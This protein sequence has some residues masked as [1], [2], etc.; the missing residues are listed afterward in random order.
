MTI[1]SQ[2]ASW[3]WLLL[4]LLAL[5][6]LGWGQA[7]P[8]AAPLDGIWKGS[9]PVPGGQL[10]VQ[11]RFVKLTSG[12]YFATLDVPQQKVR[13][14]AVT[15]ETR[16]DTVVLTAPEANS[17]YVGHLVAGGSQLRGVWQQP[18]LRAPVQ[19][20][21]TE[22]A[23]AKPR[24]TPPYREE[25]VLFANTKENIKLGGTLTIPAGPG[26]FSAVVLL[27]DAGPQD[28]NGTTDG[29]APLGA[30]G[31]Y[32]TRRG[33]AVLRFDDRGVGRSTG[34][35]QSTTADL[36]NDAQAALSLLRTRPEIDHGHLGLIGHGE[37]GNVALLAAAQPQPPAFVVGLA[38]YGLTG[39][40]VVLQQQEAALKASKTPSSQFSAIVKRQQSIFEV[41]RHTLVGTQAQPIVANMLK[42][43]NPALSDAQAQA[44]AAEMVSARYRY[45]L[46]F[47]P[48]ETLGGVACPVL[49]LYGSA[50]A[51]LNPDNN[52]AALAKGLKNNPAV[53]VRKL[54]GVNHLFQPDPTQWPIV[55]GEAHANFSPAAEEAIR[56]WV[57]EQTAKK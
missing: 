1:T 51:L 42:Q 16:A 37:G 41:I 3:R 11:F 35:P 50:D 15:V 30:L 2:G 31:D 14:L 25:E 19:L 17:R 44:S 36:V 29:F 54:P 47:D 8:R 38:P 57:V 27:S 18:G 46:G 56:A 22:T 10:E 9:L 7:I 48:S 5:P 45:Y 53:T 13:S 49:L 23:A 33:V 55:S 40:D 6:S 12:E 34:A 28:R 39:A 24:L 20:V 52:S 43:N 21:R 4:L 26:P 32:L